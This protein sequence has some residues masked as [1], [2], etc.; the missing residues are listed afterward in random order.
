MKNKVDNNKSLLKL[1]NFESREDK[2]LV[3]Y[4]RENQNSLNINL[5]TAFIETIME[6]YSLWTGSIKDSQPYIIKNLTG[7][8]L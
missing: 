6:G 4:L 8:P 2:K 5:T 1:K 3:S 7:Y